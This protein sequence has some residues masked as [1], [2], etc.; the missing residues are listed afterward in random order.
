MGKVARAGRGRIALLLMVGAMA[1]A[2]LPVSASVDA[3]L[4]APDGLRP[5][6]DFW[7]RVFGEISEWEAIVHDREDLRRVYAIVPFHHLRDISTDESV[8]RERRREIVGAEI[9]R[10]RDRLLRL[11]AYHRDPAQLT[12][13]ERALAELFR[14]DSDPQRFLKASDSARIRAQ[15]GLRERFATAVRISGRYLPFIEG[16]FRREGLPIQL[17]RLPFVE[18][19]FDVT[20]Y[21]KVG[22]AGLWQFMPATGRQFLRVDN[23]VDERRDPYA[24][25]IAAARYLKGHFA[26]LGAW[27]IAVTAYNHGRGGMQRAV[28]EVGTTDIVEIVRRY[29]GPAFGFASKNFYAELIAAIE[30]E[31]EAD[32]YFG[33]IR[34]DPPLEF[35]TFRVPDFVPFRELARISTLDE[36]ALADWNLPLSREVRRGEILVPRG[37]ELRLPSGTG[38]VF[39]MRYASLPAAAK[40]AGQRSVH[41]TH[42][43]Q[44]GETLSQIARRHGTTVA[45]LMADNGLRNPNH[46][47]VGQNLKV[48]GNTASGGVRVAAAQPAA[49]RPAAGPV[50]HTVAPGQTLSAI[51]SRYGTTVAAISR[52]N[53]I[54]NPNQVRAGDRLRIPSRS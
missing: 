20:A 27:P 10:I 39:R 50:I 34:R 2:P 19:S 18:S 41:R 53:G 23:V 51:A 54:T 28:R 13:E 5:Q 16:V 17:T 30:V 11:H 37:F 21:S 36:Q 47:R 7:K 32:K 4:P 26:A 25:T 24:S 44:S 52:L 14:G 12:P 38:E 31:R 33:P 29:Q 8:I 6:I 40:Q 15:T 48:R 1:V 46:I 43:V 3:P 45:R 49:R 22:A 35:D 42:R 9:E